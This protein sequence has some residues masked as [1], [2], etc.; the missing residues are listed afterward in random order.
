ML[1]QR[2]FLIALLLVCSIITKRHKTSSFTMGMASKGP[3]IMKSAPMPSKISTP[4]HRAT[5][6]IKMMRGKK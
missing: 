2:L 5:M 3:V 4:T 1:V 6:G